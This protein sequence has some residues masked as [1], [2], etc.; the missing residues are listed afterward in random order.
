MVECCECPGRR[1]HHTHLSLAILPIPLQQFSPIPLTRNTYIRSPGISSS[2]YTA[3]PKV[4]YHIYKV[5]R[6]QIITRYYQQ[7]VLCARWNGLQGDLGVGVGHYYY[8]IIIIYWMISTIGLL[9]L[10]YDDGYQTDI[11]Y[12]LTL[13]RC[14]IGDI[15]YSSWKWI[16]SI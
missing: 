10:L 7:I 11:R 14:W 9:F 15:F 3:L 16:P 12:T 8:W 4:Y 2:F 13:S 1:E 5:G 6:Y